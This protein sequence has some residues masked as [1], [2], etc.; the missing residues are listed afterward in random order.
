MFTRR[1]VN[2]VKVRTGERKNG[3][4]KR[5]VI[6]NYGDYRI[7]GLFRFLYVFNLVYSQAYQGQLVRTGERIML[8]IVFGLLIVVVSGILGAYLDGIV[9]IKEKG[10]YWGIGVLGGFFGGLLIFKEIFS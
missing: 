1:A 4:Q 6:C 5:L 2:L 7:V 10:L 9:E 8:S 3:H